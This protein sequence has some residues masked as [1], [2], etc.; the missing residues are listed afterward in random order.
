MTETKA[1]TTKVVDSTPKKAD[2]AG[3]ASLKLSLAGNVPKEPS[4]K[5]KVT[6]AAAKPAEIDVKKQTEEIFG[7]INTAKQSA[8]ALAELIVSKKPMDEKLT[9]TGA[10]GKSQQTTVGERIK[11]LKQTVDSAANQ[12]VVMS[13]SVDQAEVSRQLNN[14][15]A[16]RNSIAKSLGLDTNK[17]S[18]ASITEALKNPGDSATKTK[19]EGLL[20]AQDKVDGLKTLENAPAFT[21]LIYA[22]LK[23]GGFTNPDTPVEMMANGKLKVDR[24]D[25]TDAMSLIAEAGAS[26][27]ELRNHPLYLNAVNEVFPRNENGSQKVQVITQELQNAIELGSKGNKAEQEKA[28]KAAVAQADNI[29][30]PLIAQMVKD[31]AF[32]NRQSPEVLKEMAN[33]VVMAETARLQYA[34]F[35]AEQGRFGEAQ[36]LTL[37]VKAEC[38]DVMYNRGADGQIHYN[39]NRFV[40]LAKLDKQMAASSTFDP[41]KLNTDINNFR[42]QFQRLQGGNTDSSTETKE[43]LYGK[44]MNNTQVKADLEAL[45]H[46]MDG[47]LATQ[48]RELTQ[49]KQALDAEKAKLEAE[50][51][52]L[53]SKTFLTEEAGKIEAKRIEDQIKMIDMQKG[54]LD[55]QIANNTKNTQLVRLLEASYDLSR[56]DRNAANA[57]LA[58]IERGDPEFVAK[59]REVL[60]Q[61][62]DMAK[63]PGWWDSWGKKLC[64]V[65]AV[66]VGVAAGIWLGPGAIATGIAAGSAAATALGVGAVGTSMLVTAGAVGGVTVLGLGAGT[67][68]GAMTYGARKLADN[69]NGLALDKAGNPIFTRETAWQ[70]AGD[71]F[72]TAGYAAAFTALPG[73]AGGIAKATTVVGEGTVAAATTTGVIGRVAHAAPKMLTFGTTMTAGQTAIDVASGHG[74]EL[75]LKGVAGQLALNSVLGVGS[76]ISETGL[77]ART[78]GRVVSTEKLAPTVGALTYVG[79][80]Q[81][82]SIYSDRAGVQ[83]YGAAYDG[84]RNS[85]SV[86]GPWGYT[87]HDVS[88]STFQAAQVRANMQSLDQGQLYYTAKPYNASTFTG[89]N[90]VFDNAARLAAQREAN[91]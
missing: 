50:Q 64:I 71:A 76:A 51:K 30:V 77:M 83:E 14:N 39:D 72:R 85:P 86:I 11:E 35:L 29:N 47:Q 69:T 36:A 88:K 9:V 74:S 79:I 68:A 67:A 38:P 26:S 55:E 33:T 28:L 57:K 37:R 78:L 59:N 1:E 8:D 56:E 2:E 60:D 4:D 23:G 87:P 53:G 70:D 66:V 42:T 20:A 41:N 34:Q 32:A 43:S 61:M 73:A 81:G 45:G 10:D 46:S 6:D 49:S 21:K 13:K 25:V 44:G 15:L 90:S 65:G 58:E 54:Q 7:R 84:F 63:E 22:Q 62:K 89:S 52:G 16:E 5:T 91:K 40:D 19:L 18:S 75:T 80:T 27:K 48:K 82:M 31:P 3:D 12:A 17:L 24:A